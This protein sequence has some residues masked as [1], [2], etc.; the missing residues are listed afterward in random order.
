MLNKYAFG[1]FLLVLVLGF[2]SSQIRVTPSAMKFVSPDVQLVKLVMESWN[3]LEVMRVLD[4]GRKN[5]TQER[6]VNSA[7]LAIVITGYCCEMADVILREKPNNTKQALDYAF[8]LGHLKVAQRILIHR[9]EHKI[10]N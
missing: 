3:I 6:D 10:N 4:E 2:L 7:L 8:M 5:G 9:V 1:V